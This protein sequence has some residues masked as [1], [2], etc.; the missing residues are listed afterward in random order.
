MRCIPIL[1]SFDF[2]NLFWNLFNHLN[3]KFEQTRTC[4]MKRVKAVCNTDNYHSKKVLKLKTYL[5][6][7]FNSAGL[8]NAE[9]T[10]ML[11]FHNTFSAFQFNILI[12]GYIN[13]PWHP[14]T[15]KFLPHKTLTLGL[16]R[17]GSGGKGGRNERMG[18]GQEHTHLL[19]CIII[20]HQFR[21][22]WPLEY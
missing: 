15:R 21:S 6:R 5:Y 16:A 14:Y 19:H 1:T 12:K 2:S 13:I 20:W 3:K 9:Y 7:V 4:S 22:Y 17:W 11:T 18:K 8:I 10:R